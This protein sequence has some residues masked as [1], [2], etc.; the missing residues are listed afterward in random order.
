MP[1]ASKRTPATRKPAKPYA[2]FPLFP[3]ATGRWAKK[4]RGRF[5]FFGPWADPQGALARYVAQRDDLYAGRVPRDRGPVAANA[6]STSSAPG[7]GGEAT[8]RDLVNHFLTAK[9]RRMDSGDMGRRSFA[10]YHATCG[11]LVEAFGV[12]RLVDDL[13]SSDFGALR[14]GIAEKRGPVALGNEIGRVRSVFKYGYDAGLLPRPVRF[15]PEFVKPPKRMMRQAKRARGAKM[16]EAKE[17]R[18]LVKDASPA[19]KAMILL[20]INCGMGNTDIAELPRSAV[21]LKK[22]ILD[23]PRS[24]T[25]ISRRAVL[26]PETVTAIKA[27][28]KVRPK[29]KAADDRDLVFITKQGQRWVRVGKPGAKSAGKSQAVVSDAVGLQFGK[30]LR[31]TTLQQP[32]RGFYSLRHTFRT[33]ADAVGDQ[34]AVERV[35]GHENGSDIATHY[36]E[37]V[38]DDRLRA[39]SDAVQTWAFRGPAKAAR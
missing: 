23:F 29:P 14:S 5:A 2:D 18:T 20:G 17:I 25:G 15:G 28:L 3:H 10:D 6:L 7:S 16:F 13:S 9:Q 11:R 24:K 33:V 1:T 27:A 19:L 39:V 38:T 36:V 8:L 12:H 22:G 35:M 37:R 26:W 32:G 31:E 34:R 30:L 4:I 21:D